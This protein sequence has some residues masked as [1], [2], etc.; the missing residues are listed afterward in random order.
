MAIAFAQVSI[1]TRSKGHSSVAGSAYRAGDRRIDF[2]TG[3]MYDFRNRK[4]VLHSEL[5]LPDVADGCFKSGEA[6]WNAAEAME[7]RKDSQVAKDVVLALPKELPLSQQMELARDFANYHFVS[8]GLAVEFAVH[9]H[10]DGNPH[11]HIYLTTRR[12]YAHGFDTY[13]ARDL[14]PGFANSSSGKGF[15]SE[16]DYWGEQWREFQNGFFEKN[17]LGLTVDENHLISQRHEGRVRGVEPHYVK[18]K[19]QMQRET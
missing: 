15:V 13:K 11:A 7:N 4:D 18:E 3:E 2:R 10:S 1:H 8:K 5:M 6:L 19:N 17:A 14:N 9:D 16:G 12:L